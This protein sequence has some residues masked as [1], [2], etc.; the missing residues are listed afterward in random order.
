MDNG[1]SE[2]IERALECREGT[3]PASNAGGDS[4]TGQGRTVGGRV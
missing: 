3:A 1:R 2:E 4:R